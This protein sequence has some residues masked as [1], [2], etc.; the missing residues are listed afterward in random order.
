MEK[1]TEKVQATIEVTRSG[2]LD[3]DGQRYRLEQMGEFCDLYNKK[4]FQFKLKP[5][6]SLVTPT[7]MKNAFRALSS[8]GYQVH[9]DG[10]EGG[11]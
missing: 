11:V 10:D 6:C 2:Y 3:I 9:I 8:F 1:L 7:Q 5:W 4:D